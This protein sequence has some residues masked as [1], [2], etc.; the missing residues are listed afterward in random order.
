MS[1]EF[2]TEKPVAITTVHANGRTQ[3][4]SDIREILQLK[5]GD[6]VLWYYRNG[7]VYIENRMPPRPLFGPRSIIYQEKD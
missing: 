2:P 7:K 1:T 6:R 4:P 5:D 3:I